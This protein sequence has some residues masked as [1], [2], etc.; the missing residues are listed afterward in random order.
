MW[1]VGRSDKIGEIRPSRRACGALVDSGDQIAKIYHQGASMAQLI[2]EQ[3]CGGAT[4][5]NAM[6]KCN[7]IE[8]GEDPKTHF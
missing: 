5:L 3:P 2:F 8:S 6:T 7:G 1:S 4:L